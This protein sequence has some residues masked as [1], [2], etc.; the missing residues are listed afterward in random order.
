MVIKIPTCD[1]AS[2]PQGFTF[3]DFCAAPKGFIND[4]DNTGH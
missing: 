1:G 2:G 4:G 3:P